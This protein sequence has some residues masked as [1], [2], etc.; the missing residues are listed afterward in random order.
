MFSVCTPAI[1]SPRFVP[2]REVPLSTVH[3]LIIKY[4]KALL[5]IVHVWN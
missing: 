5:L 4:R 2:N 3:V 1:C